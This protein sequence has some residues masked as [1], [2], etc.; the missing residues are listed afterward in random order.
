M[1][2]AATVVP[3]YGRVQLVQVTPSDCFPLKAICSVPIRTDTLPVSP[4]SDVNTTV[5][6]SPEA[7][8]SAL[9]RVVWTYPSIFAHSPGYERTTIGF[10]KVP[11]NL[12]RYF[13]L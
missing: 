5:T 13:P 1:E 7:A 11:L 2:C 10:I 12:L 9:A 4:M 6:G 8:G 3:P